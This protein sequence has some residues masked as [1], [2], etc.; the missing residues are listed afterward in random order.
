MGR[1]QFARDHHIT[2]FTAAPV[3]NVLGAQFQPRQ[4]ELRIDAAL[5]TIACVG[6]DALLAARARDMRRIEPGRFDENVDGAV[7]AAAFH[8]AHHAGNAQRVRVIG[9]HDGVGVE[10]VGLFI[11][12]QHGLAVLGHAGAQ[13]AGQ[14]VGVEHMQ[15]AAAI[16]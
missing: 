15:R 11:Q 14:L 10:R 9:D 7:E 5:E 3:Q 1:R 12:R 8:P 6:N 16:L 2:G 4:H 13:T